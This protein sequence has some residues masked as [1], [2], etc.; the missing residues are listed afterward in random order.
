MSPRST[1]STKYQY[2]QVYIGRPSLNKT[3]H[4]YPKPL[5]SKK[6]VGPQGHVAQMG[7]LRLGVWL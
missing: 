3:K 1:W 5:N 7:K 4:L 2:R 6:E